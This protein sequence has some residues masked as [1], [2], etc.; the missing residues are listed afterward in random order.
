MLFY[1]PFVHSA[2]MFRT[3]VIGRVGPYDE[4]FR[5]SMDYELWRRIAR[6]ARVANVAE[7]LVRWRQH[8]ASMTSTYGAVTREGVRLRVEMLSELLGWHG[9]F[10]DR[11]RALTRMQAIVVGTRVEATAHELARA[12]DDLRRLHSAFCLHHGLAPETCRSHGRALRH[13]LRQRLM[14]AARRA[15]QQGE[16][17]DGSALAL[18]ALRTCAA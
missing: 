8:S 7:P 14:A 18:A 6:V 11:E 4:S 16:L 15:V 10:E 5:Y 13:E 2:T 3:N 12:A 17:R 1:C 9:G